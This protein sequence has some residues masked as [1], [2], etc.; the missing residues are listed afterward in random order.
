MIDKRF[1]PMS[2]FKSFL[3]IFLFS[4]ASVAQT[5]AAP[6]IHGSRSHA[7]PLPAEGIQHQHG[8]GALGKSLTNND[9]KYSDG[10]SSPAQDDP[11]FELPRLKK[12]REQYRRSEISLHALTTSIDNVLVKTVK[13]NNARVWENQRGIAQ[14]LEQSEYAAFLLSVS[15]LLASKKQKELSD[16]YENLSSEMALSFYLPAGIQTGGVSTGKPDCKWYNSR[17]LSI[18]AGVSSVLNQHLIAVRNLYS[19]G[20]TKLAQ[21]GLCALSNDT[22]TLSDFMYSVNGV[23]RVYYEWKNGGSNIT[24]KNTC[25]YNSKSVEVLRQ[26]R[27]LM[28]ADID[29]QVIQLESGDTSMSRKLV[30]CD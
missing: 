28:K 4:I 1:L 29:S 22:P 16:Y 23:S 3:C 15:K 6:H 30:G 18:D 11:H 14:A 12:I 26:I 10:S 17:G 19:M 13:R 7:H 2:I 9:L 25:Y 27:E 5:Y 21:A 20:E 8:I 24:H